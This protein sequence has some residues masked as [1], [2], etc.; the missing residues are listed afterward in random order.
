[1]HDPA[2]LEVF[3]HRITAVAEAMGATLQ[4]AAYSTNIKERLDFSCAV[5]DADGRT[6]AQAAHIPVHLGA[7][8]A[9]VAAARGRVRKWLPGDIVALN[10]PYLGGS[11]LPDI[12]TV[13]PVFAPGDPHPCVLVA[14][15][16]HHSDVGGSAPGSLPLA[17]D[18]YGE[19]LVL[20][21]VRLVREGQLDE[22][23]M[24][25][26]CA[27]TRTPEERRGDIQA[28]LAAHHTGA[29]RL[30]ELLADGAQGFS[31]A[32]LALL[33]YTERRARTQLERLKDGQYSFNDVIEDDG[34]SLDELTIQVSVT[35]DGSDLTFD[36]AGS[37]PQVSGSVNAPLAVTQSAVFYV[38]ACLL[39][40]V[41]VN[42]GTFAPVT[43][44][45]DV[46][47]VVNP[48]S[49]APVSAGNVETS[50]RIVDVVL[51]AL[52]DAAPDL[53]PAASQGT[54]NNLTV[55]GIDPRSGR[56]FTYYETIGGGAGASMSRPGGSALQVHMT[57]TRNT[58]IEALETAFPLR[59]SRY[60]VRRGSGGGGAHRGGAGIERSI[61]FL[62]PTTV[63]LVT[64]RRTVPP[65]PL[66]GGAPGA[67][68]TN[69][70]RSGDGE[71][72]LPSKVT[73]DAQAGDEIVVCTPGGGGWGAC[74]A[75]TSGHGAARRP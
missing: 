23:L 73:F 66:E 44:R 55:G 31:D 63:T 60:A 72:P 58:P 30:T 56:A 16:A 62:V 40:D 21:P 70:L 64:E 67:C 49:P 22:D 74:G 42:A 24:S 14:T 18:L 9:A 3:R 51:G 10:D 1:M 26:V 36:F 45:A 54:M 39:D 29:E 19:G 35:V 46:G 43:V 28:Q 11:H 68:G 75:R 32:A 59:V 2:A 48:V 57:N 61:Q 65:W 6:L 25:L 8:P 69:S 27:N 37:A 34:H 47:T 53:V 15:R 33:A 13:S 17:R 71:T 38:V 41:P 4:R 5:F 52:A 12:T 7:M 50:Q 20:P